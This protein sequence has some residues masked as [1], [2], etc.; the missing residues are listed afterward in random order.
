MVVGGQTREFGQVVAGQRHPH[1]GRAKA[2]DRGDGHLAPAQFML[3]AL[4]AGR[5]WR[6]V[7][8]HWDS[9]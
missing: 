8:G 4:E 6:K 3:D 2:L 1:H 5:D 9:R 7:K